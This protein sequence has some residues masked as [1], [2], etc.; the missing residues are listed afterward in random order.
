[1]TERAGGCNFKEVFFSQAPLARSGVPPET[2]RLDVANLVPTAFE[3]GLA[4][5]TRKTYRSGAGRCVGF[6]ERTG[7]HSFP[8]REETVF[9]FISQLHVEGLTQGTMKH[10]LAA[11]RYEQIGRGL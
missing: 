10:Y 1:M 2:A 6:C 9:L 8:V 4:D 11:V 3:S 5:K 7:R